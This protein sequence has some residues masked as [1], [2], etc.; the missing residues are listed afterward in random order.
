MTTATDTLAFYDHFRQSYGHLPIEDDAEFMIGDYGPTGG[1][2]VGEGGEFKVTLIALGNDW[3]DRRKLTPH[4]HVFGDALG[5]LER[6][7]TMGLGDL[8]Q[9]TYG[10][11]DAFSRALIASGFRDQSAHPIGH[12]PNCQ[13]CGQPVQSKA[14]TDERKT[15]A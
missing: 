7:L 3:R 5:S 6:A 11:A 2:G 14:M 4:L 15:D 13:C 12:K 1:G 10:S 9:E 8:L